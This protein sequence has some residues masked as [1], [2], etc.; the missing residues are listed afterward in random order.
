MIPKVWLLEFVTSD[1]STK[2]AGN[3]E[4]TMPNF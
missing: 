3:A 4:S 2:A 1:F